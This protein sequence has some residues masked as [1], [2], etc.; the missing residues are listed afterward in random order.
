M[1]PATPDTSDDDDDVI[2]R[3]WLGKNSNLSRR[4]MPP[5]HADFSHYAALNQ[6]VP[7]ASLGYL[8]WQTATAA[9][10]AMAHA[11]TRDEDTA[12]RL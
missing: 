1:K 6:A 8:T 10:P 12:L 5:P 9:S 11:F 3:V 2:P 4:F 7:G